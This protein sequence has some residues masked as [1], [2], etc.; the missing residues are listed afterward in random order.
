M[1]VIIGEERMSAINFQT[2]EGRLWR[3]A[4]NSYYWGRMSRLIRLLLLGKNE[5]TYSS[6]NISAGKI[7]KINRRI[8]VI[9]G[10]NEQTY[11]SINTDA[12]AQNNC[13]E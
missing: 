2:R 11:S 8:S 10:K 4:L 13:T 12:H 1:S 3:K 5:Q 7:G 6:I 9:I